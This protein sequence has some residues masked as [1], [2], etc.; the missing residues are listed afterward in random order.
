MKLKS[1]LLS[2]TC[3]TLMAFAMN[4][5]ANLG[6]GGEEPITDPLFNEAQ[7]SVEG[8]DYKGG[9]AALQDLARGGLY[10]SDLFNLIGYAQRKLGDLDA[11]FASYRKALGLNPAHKGAHE[12]IGEAY[13]TAGDLDSAERHLGELK[14]ICSPVPCGEI[15]RLHDEIEAYKAKHASR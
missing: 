11:A 9:L 7:R 3:L 14:R 13:L 10:H 4:A 2:L 1:S 12:Y 5:P 6:G 8:G 15:R